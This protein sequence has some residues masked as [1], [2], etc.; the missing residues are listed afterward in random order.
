MVPGFEYYMLNEFGRVKKDAPHL[1]MLV[2]A[3]AGIDEAA[4]KVAW[5]AACDGRPGSVCIK[6]VYD[7][8]GLADYIVK[9]RNPVQIPA[10]WTGRRSS[11]MSRGFL[12]ATKKVLLREIKY[13]SSGRSDELDICLFERRHNQSGGTVMSDTDLMA[14]IRNRGGKVTARD[15][16]RHLGR[17]YPTA[18]AAFAA[19]D[20]WAQAG[21]GYWEPSQPGPQGGR[22]T[23]YFVLAPAGPPVTPPP[24][25]SNGVPA[26]GSDAPSERPPGEASPPDGCVGGP[27]NFKLGNQAVA[28]ASDDGPR[29]EGDGRPDPVEPPQAAAVPQEGPGPGEAS[30]TR[31]RASNASPTASEAGTT[32]PAS[33]PNDKEAAGP[34]PP[35]QAGAG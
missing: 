3:P 11:S 4:V 28:I 24:G 12:A 8:E 31:Q 16:Q 19:L 7:P 2:T 13:P 23:R 29:T 1:H 35:A 30:G 5:A 6:P 18:G 20:A 33:S 14:W 10:N 25:G 15:V 32:G 22:R 26:G 21:D 9:V 27:F 17:H 34:D